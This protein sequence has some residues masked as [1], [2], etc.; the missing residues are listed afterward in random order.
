MLVGGDFN[1]IR[2]EEEKNNSNFNARWPV[3]FNSIIESLELKELELSGRQFTWASQRETP[4][5]EKLD[6]FLASV[7]WEQKYPL[8]SVHAMTRT[9]SDHTPLLIDSGDEAHSGN[10]SFFFFEQSWM[11]QDGFKEMVER[12]WAY[13]QEGNTPIEIWQNKIRH[14]RQFLRGWAKNLN[15]EY[16]RLK[17]KLLQKIDQLDIKAETIILNA[18]EGAKKRRSRDSIR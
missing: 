11:R 15:A 17:E 3:I 6:R 18:A 2:R 1:I 9:G 12:E 10:K 16:R 5:Y 7:E 8:V 14:I 4:T 13:V